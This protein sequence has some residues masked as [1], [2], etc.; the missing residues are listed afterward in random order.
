MK[1][2]TIL[3]ILSLLLT[4]CFWDDNDFAI[5]KIVTVSQNPVYLSALNSKYDDYN[6]D[7]DPG[8]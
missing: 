5:E 2:L 3:T 6:S 7:I 1:K 4:G 8:E